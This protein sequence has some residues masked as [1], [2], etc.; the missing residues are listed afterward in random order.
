MYSGSAIHQ[1]RQE[2][3]QEIMA[4]GLSMEIIAAFPFDPQ[5]MALFSRQHG[6]YSPN[7]CAS[8][9]IMPDSTHRRS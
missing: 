3:M 7:Y 6:W 8:M 9:K 1:F 4:A 5:C 2:V